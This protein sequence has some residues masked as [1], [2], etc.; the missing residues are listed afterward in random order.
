MENVIA[1]DVAAYTQILRRHPVLANRRAPMDVRLNSYVTL[2]DEIKT[3]EVQHVDVVDGHVVTTRIDIFTGSFVV[4]IDGVDV[5]AG[6]LPVTPS[7]TRDVVDAI[8]WE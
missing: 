1:R 3:Y 2:F 6:P 7:Q 4:K 8:A 5:Y